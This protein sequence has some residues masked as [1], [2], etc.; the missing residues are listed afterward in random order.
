MTLPTI[1]TLEGWDSP[2]E[3]AVEDA[4][5]LDQGRSRA[6]RFCLGCRGQ[7]GGK[8]AEWQP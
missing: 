4:N 6:G 7:R 3:V 5:V 1:S 8:E 2:D